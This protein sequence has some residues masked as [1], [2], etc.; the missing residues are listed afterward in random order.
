MKE[1]SLQNLKCLKQLLLSLNTCIFHYFSFI[2]FYFYHASFMSLSFF[3][4]FYISNLNIFND[5]IFS[6]VFYFVI[7]IIK[8]IFIPFKYTM[9]CLLKYTLYS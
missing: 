4:F 1:L 5:Y 6:P 7:L 2:F 3:I 8:I 9:A